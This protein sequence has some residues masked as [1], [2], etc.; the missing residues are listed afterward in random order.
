VDAYT[1]EDAIVSAALRFGCY[2]RGLS[3]CGWKRVV[4]VEPAS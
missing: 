3:G 2:E 4:D 1:A